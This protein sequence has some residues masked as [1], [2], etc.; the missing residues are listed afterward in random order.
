MRALCRV[1]WRE[2]GII[3]R[4]PLLWIATMG[5]PLFSAIF[6][7]TI[8][9]DGAIREIP[10]AVIDDDF[11]PTS[12]SIIRTI[13]SSPTLT[14]SHHLRSDAEALVAMRRGEIYGYVRIP[15][16]LS[17]SMVRGTH[18]AISYYYHYAFM[19]IGAQVEATL[20]TLLTIVS[21]EPQI[22]TA[23]M[24]G[25]PDNQVSMLIDPLADDTHPLGNASLNYRTYLAEPIFF[26]V[27][28]I[29]MLL[30]IVY[31]LGQERARGREWF[32][33][34]DHNLTIALVGKLTPYF[35]AFVATGLASLS[36][37]YG[38][39][40]ITPSWGM[41]VA[42]VGLV[43]ASLSL[44]TF[45]YSLSSNVSIT[46]S[47]ASV[48][49][50]LGATLSGVTFPVASMYPIFRYVALLLPIR[51]FTIITQNLLYTEGGYGA[52]WWHATALALFLLLPF[53][54]ASRLR[55]SI[56]SKDYG[57]IA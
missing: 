51:H 32:D 43:V 4:R 22:T 2:V 50:S 23:T 33:A 21:I 55:R 28:Q 45:I 13:E 16:N 31:T 46:L 19:S 25:V 35:C 42:M 1:V 40:G 57:E 15:S 7:C 49:G 41:V 3:A 54:A 37:I 24:L 52:I 27:F 34:S 18:S 29:V 48:I 14:V 17:R 6:M 39:V 26:V 36:M 11:T 20:R 47:A 53:L 38:I 44:A 12:R 9:G 5:L 30:T 56:T 8:F 10:I